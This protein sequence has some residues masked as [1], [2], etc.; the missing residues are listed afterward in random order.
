MYVSPVGHGEERELDSR[1]NP[2]LFHSI[3]TP[4]AT[5]TDIH[6]DSVLSASMLVQLYGYKILLTWPATETNRMYFKDCHGTERYVRLEEAIREM[7]GL[8]VMILKPGDGVKMEPGKLHA[9]LSVTNSVI[10]CWEYVDAKWPDDD[11]IEKG[12]LWELD[13]IKKCVSAPVPT[14]DK[15]EDM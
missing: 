5:I 7:A 9:V 4:A 2:P 10:S 14:D 1:N 6:D 3:L 13:L 8:K 11:G 15:A 12:I